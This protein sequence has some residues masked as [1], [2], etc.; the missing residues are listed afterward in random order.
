MPGRVG[1]AGDA[2]AILAN[3]PRIVRQRLVYAPQDFGG[4]WRVDFE[5]DVG[6]SD[7]GPVNLG[8]ASG[9]VGARQASLEVHGRFYRL[10][11]VARTGRLIAMTRVFIM[12]LGAGLMWAQQ[13]DVI[14]ADI[15]EGARNFGNF[16]A[17]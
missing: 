4:T 10:P 13:H 7:D 9:V 16:C 8:D 17:G 6:G 12:L 3:K 14:P 15:E 1:V 2:A 5:R 11:V